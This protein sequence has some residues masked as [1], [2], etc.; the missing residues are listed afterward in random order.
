MSSIAR[1]GYTSGSWITLSFIHCSSEVVGSFSPHETVE[2]EGNSKPQ[3]CFYVLLSLSWNL[4][5][6]L[7]F[8]TVATI[9]HFFKFSVIIAF[10]LTVF[11]MD[12]FILL[13]VSISPEKEVFSAT[14]SSA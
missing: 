11:F 6:P 7:L 10:D 3:S 1:R 8:S 14:S 13:A 2:E 9:G 12:S 5:P 4:K